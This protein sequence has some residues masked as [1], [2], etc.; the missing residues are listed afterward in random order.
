MAKICNIKKNCDKITPTRNNQKSD[1]IFR[2]P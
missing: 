1:G 2:N